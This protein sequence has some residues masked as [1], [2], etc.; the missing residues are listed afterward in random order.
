[1]SLTSLPQEIRNLALLEKWM[2]AQGHNEKA[3]IEGIFSRMS[4]FLNKGFLYY[5]MNHG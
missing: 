3:N 4:G 2:P 5:F 1:M